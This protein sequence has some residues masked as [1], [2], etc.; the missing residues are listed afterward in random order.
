MNPLTMPIAT[1]QAFRLHGMEESAP[2][3]VALALRFRH[4]V[5]PHSPCWRKFTRVGP[6]PFAPGRDSSAVF[7]PT[8]TLPHQGGGKVLWVPA[9]KI[10]TLARVAEEE[11]GRDG[12]ETLDLRRARDGCDATPEPPG[13]AR[14]R[15]CR[16]DAQYT[17]AI[18]PRSGCGVA[19]SSAP[20]GP[21]LGVG[22][23]AGRYRWCG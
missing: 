19:R 12:W 8:Q 18:P 17:P 3:G 6:G 7:T 11:D 2:V 20:S 21:A 9:G 1:R 23:L 14:T 15:G 13:R 22:S 10:P 5:S 4:V 16:A